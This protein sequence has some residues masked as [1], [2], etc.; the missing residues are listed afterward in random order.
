MELR[1]AYEHC[2]WMSLKCPSSRSRKLHIKYF[3]NGDR[4]DDDVN[5]SGI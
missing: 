3:K 5:G 4:Y 1:L 2:L